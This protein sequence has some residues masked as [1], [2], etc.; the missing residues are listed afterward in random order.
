[1]GMRRKIRKLGL[2]QVKCPFWPFPP[3]KS[4]YFLQFHPLRCRHNIQLPL[5]HPEH[6]GTGYQQVN[7]DTV[8]ISLA[9]PFNVYCK[10]QPFSL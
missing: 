7:N 10:I 4:F 6:V 5:S 3:L 2:G 1:M 8:G 9:Q